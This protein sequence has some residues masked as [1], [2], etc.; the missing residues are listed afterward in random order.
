MRHR[1]GSALLWAQCCPPGWAPQAVSAQGELKGSFSP[2]NFFL[3]N[4]FFFAVILS[5]DPQSF[6]ASLKPL[7]QR[8]SMI[9]VLAK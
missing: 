7:G 9:S 4:H 8:Y 6:P 3:N 1:I 2:E 5:N